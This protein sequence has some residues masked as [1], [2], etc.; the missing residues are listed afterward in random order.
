[1]SK[2]VVYNCNTFCA[3]A[4][5]SVTRD[6][7]L[8]PCVRS[9]EVQPVLPFDPLSMCLQVLNA[10][11]LGFLPGARPR[12]VFVAALRQA[13]VDSYAAGYHS[14]PVPCAPLH[15]APPP[16]QQTQV[17]VGRTSGG[18]GG[19]GAAWMRVGAQRRGCDGATRRRAPAAYLDW[20]CVPIGVAPEKWER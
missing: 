9:I 5:L 3:P 12:A 4:F 19:G 20:A 16:R 10:L 14:A 1:M 2:G 18:Q 13:V 7:H 6:S 11:H 17:Q 15:L 8:R